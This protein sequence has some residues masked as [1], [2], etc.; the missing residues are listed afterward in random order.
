MPNLLSPMVALMAVAF[1][2]GCGQS[3][4]VVPD[5]S[6]AAGPVAPGS[7]EEGVSLKPSGVFAYT[8]INRAPWVLIGE[9]K[10]DGE[11]Q[12]ADFVGRAEPG[13]RHPAE[14]AA[15]ELWQETGHA[16]DRKTTEGELRE[17]EPVDVGNNVFIY[18]L[19]VQYRDADDLESRDRVPFHEKERYCWIPY[20]ELTES[21]DDS[22]NDQPRSQDNTAHVPTRCEGE[23]TKIWYVV[24]RNLD[25]GKPLRERLDSLLLP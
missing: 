16:Y 22:K 3:A 8:F 20:S 23:S 2:F 6:Q 14:V 9:E 7:A 5:D 12:W 15:R 18:A 24:A 25:V 13:E 19:E 10:R 1:L 4:P 17:L 11:Y 21:I